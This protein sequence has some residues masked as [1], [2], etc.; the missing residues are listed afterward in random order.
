MW[1]AD[2]A[3]KKVLIMAGEASGDLHGANLAREIGKLDPSLVLYGVGSKRMRE[4]GVRMLADASEISV[5]GITAVLTHIGAIYRV[6]AKLK[7]FLNDEKPDLLI[8]IDFPDFNIRLG[9]AARKLGIPVLYYIS[10]QVWVWRKGRIRKIARLVKAMIVV[11]PFEVPLYEKAGVDVRF[12][13]HP[14]TDVVRSELTPEQAKTELGL[15]A[16]RRTVALLPGSRSSEIVHLLPDMLAAATILTSRFP[17]LQFVL[18]VAP[19]LDR[20]YVS[21]FVGRCGVPVRLVEGRAY[22]ALRA[23]DAAIVASGTAT[24]ETGLMAVPMVI[25]YKISAL[26]YFILTK[27]VRGVKDVGLV[28]IVAGRRIVPE[29][30]QKD[31]TPRNMADAVAAMLNDTVYYERIRSD[32]FAIRAGLGEA[33]ASAR[34]AAVV[35]EVLAQA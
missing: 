2:P 19:T 6:Y 21:G 18:P 11:F 34:A 23:S 17:D 12:V 8:L 27:L 31:S 22:D 14:L 7:R 1:N 13:G 16:A 4:S 20:A 35:K 26:N 30:V 5:V 9:R 32:L 29:L 28:N 15:D 10:P 3:G 25:V 24:L 33:G